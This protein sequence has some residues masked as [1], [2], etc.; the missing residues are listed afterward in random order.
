MTIEVEL[1]DGSIVEFPDDTKPAAMEMALA[2]Y[3]ERPAK[4]AKPSFSN[5]IGGSSDFVQDLPATQPAISAN[6]AYNGPLLR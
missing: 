4:T 2:K 1:P 3:R 5:V 6:D